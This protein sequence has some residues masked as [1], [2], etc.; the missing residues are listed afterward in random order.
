MKAQVQPQLQDQQGR[1]QQQWWQ[2][3]AANDP[4]YRHWHDARNAEDE[5]AF[6]RWLDTPEGQIW[7]DKE[8]ALEDA[9]FTRW[10]DTPDGM[11][12]LDSQAEAHIES[13][14]LSHWNHDGFSPV[15]YA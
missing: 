8:R 1:D 5:A 6:D 4:A 15:I 2:Q 7:L 14:G 9:K 11:L 3:Q 10:L 12:W 13:M